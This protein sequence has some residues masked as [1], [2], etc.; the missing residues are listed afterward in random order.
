MSYSN[1]I[2]SV[3]HDP[4]GYGSILQTYKDAHAKNPAITKNEVTWWFRK[5]VPQKTK[6]VGQ[7]SFVA[8]RPYQEYQIDLFFMK[9]QK[10][11]VA[12][13]IID[14]FTK[15]IVVIPVN[16]KK[17]S[18]LALGLIE[19]IHKMG[20][21]PETIYSDNEKALSSAPMQ[22][23]YQEQNITHIATR[24][25]A[26]VAERAVRT[27]KDMLYKRMEASEE[28]DPQWTDFIYPVL[29]TYNNKLVHHS[30]G[31]TP[32]EAKESKNHL[33]AKINMELKAKHGRT[34]KPINIGDK[35]KIY[36]KKLLQN[37]KSNVSYWSDKTYTIKEIK[38]V[39]GQTFYIV[40]EPKIRPLLR[41]EI[42]KTHGEAQ[43]S[44]E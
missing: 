41:H 33:T 15:Y 37:Q 4:A 16:G 19:G 8:Q 34:Y 13:L 36:K 40:E 14:I 38:Q 35:V 25:I 6:M 3:Y 29:L 7:N 32:K 23:Y 24:S 2:S 20:H 28:E 10:A 18:D 11:R 31:L 26:P 30:T 1:I 5:N 17:T 43:E 44:S 12:L 9:K 42:L 22:K 39:K 21:K 27:I